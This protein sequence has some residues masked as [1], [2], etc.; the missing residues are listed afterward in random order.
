MIWTVN[1]DEGPNKARKNKNRNGT[2]REGKDR[3]VTGHGENSENSAYKTTQ[4]KGQDMSCPW[5]M[6]CNKNKSAM[7]EGGERKKKRGRKL[8]TTLQ[9]GHG[10]S[11]AARQG[12]DTCSLQ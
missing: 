11:P 9:C 10:F 3:R 6:A 1:E 7:R 5:N 4:K 8:G 12:R 2:E